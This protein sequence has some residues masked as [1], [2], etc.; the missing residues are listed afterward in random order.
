MSDECRTDDPSEFVYVPSPAS[1]LE[2]YAGMSDADA[3]RHL[4]VAIERN[5]DLTQDALMLRRVAVAIEAKAEK[6]P[7]PEKFSAVPVGSICPGLK[8]RFIDII[9]D[10]RLREISLHDHRV[11]EL[12][13]QIA[14]IETEIS[15]NESI[16]SK[17]WRA[18]CKSKSDY[19][20]AHEWRDKKWKLLVQTRQIQRLRI[21][22]CLRRELGARIAQ[23]RGKINKTM[24]Q[25]T[26][27]VGKRAPRVQHSN[28]KLKS[29]I[30]PPTPSNDAS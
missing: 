26:A 10:E 23:V 20:S 12:E 6:A 16:V 24:S 4:A 5:P 2:A 22:A 19:F 1:D 14:D 13:K 11:M 21:E 27:G 17:A 8:R 30:P 18:Y 25:D 15:G 28:R 29:N 7:L 9:G 3:L